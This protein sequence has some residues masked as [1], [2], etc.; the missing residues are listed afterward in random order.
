MLRRSASSNSIAA[1]SIEIQGITLGRE[2]ILPE[3]YARR[4]YEPGL[5]RSGADSGV[6]RSCW[7][8]RPPTAWTRPISSCRSS[9]RCP[10]R[11]VTAS[12]RADLDLLL[13]EA[14]IRYGY[15]RRFGKVNPEEMEPA[16]NFGRGFAKWRRAGAIC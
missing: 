5:D 2:D 14:L 7:P 15:Q 11:P 1:G 10:A 13:T 6:A 8:P 9:W 4:A 16:W 12:Q 3:F